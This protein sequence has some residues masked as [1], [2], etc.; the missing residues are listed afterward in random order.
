[1]NRGDR[2]AFRVQVQLADPQA[3]LEDL[4]QAAGPRTRDGSAH[5]DH[6]AAYDGEPDP[7]AFDKDRRVRRDVVDVRA[8]GKRIV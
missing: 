8:D 7:L 3:L 5:I 2:R 4:G 1:M 6:M